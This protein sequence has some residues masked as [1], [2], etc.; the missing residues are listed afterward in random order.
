MKTSCYMLFSAKY[1]AY[2]VVIMHFEGRSS[3]GPVCI[4]I[5]ILS[6]I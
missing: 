1:G 2:D 5:S 3:K 4:Q 6:T